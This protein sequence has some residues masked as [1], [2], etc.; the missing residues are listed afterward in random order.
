MPTIKRNFVRTNPKVDSNLQKDRAAIYGTARWRRL[1]MLKLVANPLCERC[2]E[3]SRVN[4]AED[5]HHKVSFMSTNDPVRRKYLAYDFDNLQS[6]CKQCHQ[7]IHNY[8][9]KEVGV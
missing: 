5:V 7:K 8:G 4:I 2:L 6:L 3:E 9:K 1:R